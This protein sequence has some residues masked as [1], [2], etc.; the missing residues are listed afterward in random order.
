[1]SAVSPIESVP[2]HTQRKTLWQAW[3]GCQQHSSLGCGVLS[4]AVFIFTYL[5]PSM[6]PQAASGS[7]LPSLGLSLLICNT[8][9]KTPP[10]SEGYV[11]TEGLIPRVCGGWRW[12]CG[13]RMFIVNISSICHCLP[14]PSKWGHRDSRPAQAS[15]KG[16][17]KS[18][19]G[20][21]PDAIYKLTRTLRK[22]KQGHL[23]SRAT[24]DLWILTQFYLLRFQSS[25]PTGSMLAMSLFLRLGLTQLA[26]L[27]NALLWVIL[28]FCPQVQWSWP[29]QWKEVR[30]WNKKVVVA[31]L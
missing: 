22:H 21:W 11:K 2:T 28:K 8:G 15:S 27:L 17:S 24:C 18:S 16:Q 10:A 20:S 30:P 4:D 14:S 12:A 26:S 25:G 13:P 5:H 29:F 6:K 1:M 7:A 23:Q 19:S 31:T 3:P 9:I